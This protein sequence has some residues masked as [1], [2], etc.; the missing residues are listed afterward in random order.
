MDARA[1]GLGII[2]AG[3]ILVAVGVL[4]W[5]G[6]LSWV[7]RLPGDVRI[8]TGNTRIYIPITT[9]ILVSVVLSLA[10]WLLRRLL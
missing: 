7:G 2:A 3:A 4:V 1:V 8:E 9:M 6:A 10:S 5:A